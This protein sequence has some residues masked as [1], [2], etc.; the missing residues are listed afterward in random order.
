MENKPGRDLTTGSIPRHLLA[1]ALPMLVGNLLSTGYSIINT[2][3]VG[4]IL[5]GNAVGATAVSFPIIFIL[6][7]LASGA[8]MAT[9]ILV[10][11]YYGAKDFSMVRKV[12]N[13]SYFISL[14]LSVI[15]TV[16]GFLFGDSLLRLVGTPPEI[17][18]DAS[19]YLRILVAGILFFYV[20]FLL[21]SI[22]RGIGDTM[23]PLIFL[24]ASTLL[25]AILDPLLI[26]G[27]GPFPKLGLN[28]AALAS[29]ISQI[30]AV[31]LGLYYINKKYP[32]LGLHPSELRFDKQIVW[33]I[34]KIGFPS[35]IQ[36][37]LVGIGAAVVT[38]FVNG[39]GATAI[40]AFGAA[41]RIDSLAMMPTMSMA[42]AASAITGQ[43]LGARKPE[44]IKSIFKWG[45]ILN[46][47]ITSLITILA[48]CIPEL[49]LSA[50]VHDK[51]I[52]SIGATYLR[53]IGPSY[54]LFAVMF[55][56]NG[57]INGSG[58]TTVTMFITLAALWF[59]R[60]PLAAF[61]SRTSLGLTGIWLAMLLG[62]AFG[63]LMSLAYY[64]SGKWKKSV[65]KFRPP[66][67]E[68]ATSTGGL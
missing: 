34:L 45:I 25:N 55:V 15:L 8:T 3:W 11:Q 40:A 53:I 58:H 46:L 1:F 6:I 5:G 24:T 28:G 35:M 62:F 14:V 16:G 7:A 18:A 30:A 52:I 36:Q 39:F 26:M 2:L 48:L 54:L 68:S 23:T 51:A 49:I 22:L 63:T 44:R 60:V 42:M 67:P 50:F 65:L 29:L 56:T 33:L 4:N 31:L 61:L 66:M 59:L 12:V 57:I 27:I 17:F 41:S 19:G 21:T 20:Y 13:N 64:Y 38:R 37:S 9:S 10:S 32:I 47:L 43:N